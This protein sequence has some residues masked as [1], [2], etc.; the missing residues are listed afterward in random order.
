MG[1]NERFFL[2]D[3]ETIALSRSD[4]VANKGVYQVPLPLTVKLPLTIR[5]RQDGDRIRLT[6]TLTKRISRYFIDKKTPMDIRDQ[7]WVVEDSAGE[8]VALLPLSI[9]I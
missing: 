2:S 7:A 6:E 8:I 3:N 9:P 1:E 4:T 5:R